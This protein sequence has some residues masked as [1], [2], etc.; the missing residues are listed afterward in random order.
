MAKSRKGALFMNT[1][2]PW[3]FT[4]FERDWYDLLAPGGA[5]SRVD[6][7]LFAQRTEK[8]TEFI[9]HSSSKMAHQYSTSA[10]G[11]VVTQSASRNAAIL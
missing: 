3:Y 11:G 6:L 9:T 8:E 2:K 10:V 4:L 7:E 5:R 1:E